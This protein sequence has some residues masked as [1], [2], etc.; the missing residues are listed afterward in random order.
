MRL[1]SGEYIE[2]NGKRYYDKDVDYIDGSIHIGREEFKLNK[3]LGDLSGATIHTFSVNGEEY[4][5]NGMWQKP[6]KERLPRKKK[7]ELK[8]R[9]KIWLKY[10]SQAL[11][12]RTTLVTEKFMQGYDVFDVNELD[13][14]RI[15][16]P[17]K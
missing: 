8:K 15:K 6:K 9:S 12:S 16:N 7:K 17:Y 1:E 3:G 2:Y 13:F 4:M 11:Y 14:N 10:Y 5:N